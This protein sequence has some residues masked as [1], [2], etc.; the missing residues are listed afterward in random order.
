[1]TDILDIEG[2][3]HTSHTAWFIAVAVLTLLTFGFLL[4][5]AIRYLKPKTKI[6]HLSA[7]ERFDSSV[8]EIARLNLVENGALKLYYA[9]LGDCLRQY[10][11]DKFR[12]P[13]LDKTSQEIISEIEAY[14]P[15]HQEVVIHFFLRADRVKFSEEVVGPQEASEDLSALKL[16]IQALEA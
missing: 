2:I 9:R 11:E 15:R 12:Y 4:R 10:L 6:I 13:A 16:V 8:S 7:G 14:L 1:M 3:V 5:F